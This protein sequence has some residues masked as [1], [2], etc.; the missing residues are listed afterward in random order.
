VLELFQ[1]QRAAASQIADRFVAYNAN[2]ATTGRRSQQRD[3][4]FYQAL[5]SITGSGKTAILA[6]AVGEIATMVEPAPVVLWLSKGKVVVAQ[7][8]A[9][10]SAGGKYNHLLGDSTVRLLSEYRPEDVEQASEAAVYFATVGTFNQRDRESS[11]LRVYRS[12]IDTTETSTWEALK[13][14]RTADGELRPLIVVYD[15]AQNLSDQQ[16]ELLLELEPAA[17]LLASATLRFP[18]RFSTEVI[19]PLRANGIADSELITSIPSAVVVESGLV[20]ATITLEGLN[21]PM[22]ESIAAMLADMTDVE[23]D[24]AA[25][26]LPFKPKAIYVSNTN[27]I[28]GD[29]G[30]AD[31]PK[32]PFSQR[33][34]PPILIWRYLTETA[35]IPASDVAVYAD[36]KTHKDFPLPADFSLFS[37]GESDYER[38]TE[39]EYRHIIFNLALQEGWDDPEAYFAYVDKSMN[40]R[41]QVTQIVG[42]VLRQPGATHYSSE[43]LNTAHFYVRLDRNSVFTEVVDEVRDGLGGDAPEVR[44]VATAPGRERPIPYPVKELRTVPKVAL[45]SSHAQSAVESV[46]AKLSDYSA[47]ATNTQ[48]AGSRRTI[49]QRI[50][51]SGAVDSEWV[52]FEHASRVSVRWAFRREVSR[53]FRPTLTIVNTDGAKFDAKVGVGSTAYKHVVDISADAVSQFLNFAQIKQ[54]RRNAYEVGSVL[55]RPS[56]VEPF[57]NALHEGYDG[58]NKLEKPFAHALDATGLPWCRNP[59]Q[60]GYKIPLLSPGATTWFFPDFLLWDG[61]NV[62]CLDTKGEHLIESDAGRK[63]MGILP[64]MGSKVRV[65]VKLISRGR[66]D[67]ERTRTSPD[68]YTLWGVRHDGKLNVSNFDDV[69]D[70]VDAIVER[71]AADAD[72]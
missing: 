41:V 6:Q 20:K 58:L 4:P 27:V 50:G 46:I 61:D 40:S 21:S 68:G 45:A 39:G 52:D 29:D 55:A 65:D 14:R 17:F 43:T 72:N 32:Q 2:P 24:A 33:Q 53:S 38:F 8:Y 36:L 25:E 37:G 11:T 64:A 42:R 48:A 62:F 70:V 13:N 28:D 16:T 31:D 51:Q 19:D 22:E 47:D 60:T 5:S 10:L 18:Q 57:T 56:E 7:S 30:L 15:E 23:A 49:T 71:G 3:V 59:S 9:N 26:G 67:A 63:L 1:F 44:L 54:Q 34:A 35:G 69:S 12:E 66:W